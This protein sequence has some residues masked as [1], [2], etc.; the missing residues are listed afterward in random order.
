[1][2]STPR[3]GRSPRR[4]RA[5]GRHRR[6]TPTSDSSTG[7]SRPDQTVVLL[8]SGPA[9]AGKTTLAEQW[10]AAGRST[11]PDCSAWR[12]TST[13]RR[14]RRCRRRRP[15]R[16]SGPSGS[17]S[18][19]AAVTGRSRVL[20]GGAARAG[21]PGG[22]PERTPYRARARR[23][24]SR[25]ATPT[26]SGS[27]APSPRRAQRVGAG[28]ALPGVDP[29]V[30]GP[31]ARR[32]PTAGAHDT[33]ISPSTPTSSPPCSAPSRSACPSEAQESLLQRTEG[34]AVALYLEALAL[35]APGPAPAAA[36]PEPV[37]DLAF[38]RDYIED[39]ILD[40]L[41]PRRPA[42]SSCGPR[43]ST[44]STRA[45]ATPS[46]VA[47]TRQSCSRRCAAAPRSSRRSTRSGPPTDTTTSSTRPRGR[48]LTS[49][50][51]ASA[52]AEL[53]DRAAALVPTSRATST[54]PCGTHPWRAT[55]RPRGASSGPTSSSPSPE[56]TR[57]AG[58]LARRAARGRRQ[59]ATP[60]LPGG[61]VVG[62]PVRRPGRDATLDPAARRRTPAGVA[63]PGQ[64]RA[65]P[66]TL[67]TLEAIVGHVE[68]SEIASLCADALEGLRP[69]IPSGR[70]RRSSA[71][72]RL[73]LM[74]DPGRHR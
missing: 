28:A 55:S 32:G 65:L 13:T 48:V 46:S 41:S 16:R 27:C 62:H 69:T 21:E 1:M 36:V 53:H 3:V 25:S 73:T 23:P 42:T 30:A 57:P 58:T 8:G 20:L 63:R 51:D 17:R 74:R 6:S 71:G 7:S 43:S 70:R 38:A 11:P 18:A 15:W 45:P 22:D 40:P 14:A 68:L 37:G 24:P 49:T 56:G 67:A 29:P 19:R 39:E 60:P 72:S 52:I 44:R 5:D 2:P 31:A 33:A 47:P 4:T 12:P 50:L 10:A 61:G 26:V 9:G 35:R 66:A 54:R 64:H 59:G 34:W